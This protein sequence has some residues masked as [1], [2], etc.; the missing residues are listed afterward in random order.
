MRNL[1][2]IDAVISLHEIARKVK[3]ETGNQNLHN[4][5]RACADDLHELSIQDDRASKVAQEII[6]QA[7]E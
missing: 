4:R 3:E 5:I 7:K 1:E 2:L 6:K